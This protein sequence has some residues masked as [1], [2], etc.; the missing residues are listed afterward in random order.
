MQLFIRV[1]VRQHRPLL[2]QRAGRNRRLARHR[3]RAR[4]AR[5]RRRRG[6]LREQPGDLRL[7]RL[8]ALLQRRV[9]HMQPRRLRD[10]TASATISLTIAEAERVRGRWRTETA[11][12]NMV[13]GSVQYQHQ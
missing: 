4:R 9:L 1:R 13:E 5:S 2:L 3:A 6:Q 11:N 8:A 7:V 10:I 12:K